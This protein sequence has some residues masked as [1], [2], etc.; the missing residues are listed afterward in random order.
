[1]RSSACS[2]NWTEIEIY[3]LCTTF[4]YPYIR[5]ICR[6]VFSV[7]F[8]IKLL[9]FWFVIVRVCL[10]QWFLFLTH[11]VESTS[12]RHLHI[13]IID[14]D[15]GKERDKFS[16]C[17]LL[18]ITWSTSCIRFWCET[19]QYSFCMHSYLYIYLYNLL[20]KRYES[21]WNALWKHA[22]YLLSLSLVR[23]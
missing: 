20:F 12:N 9:S 13:C 5:L 6:F 2:L 19:S 8:Q 3:I 23:I 4:F 18:L 21:I 17:S 10:H 14:S 1:M 15:D 11:N 22:R 7:S 16:A